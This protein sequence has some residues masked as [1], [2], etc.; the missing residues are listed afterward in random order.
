MK[1]FTAARSLILATVILVI[2]QSCSTQTRT[3]EEEDE[4]IDSSELAGPTPSDLNS[5]Q[6]E[7]LHTIIGNNTDGVIRGIKFGDPILKVKAN[8]N[9]E[10][11]EDTYLYVGYTFDTE[12]LETIDVQYLYHPNEGVN[13]INVDVYLNSKDATRQL[14]NASKKYF[15]ERYG[16]PSQESDKKIVWSEGSTKVVLDDVSLGKD[17]GLKMNFEPV[18]KSA[19]VTK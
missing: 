15:S 16:S 13:Q 6:S 2:S 18:G 10:M 11:F 19:V 14:W 7:L 1:I 3:S 12:Q 4:P 5:N 8:E 17:F 9:F